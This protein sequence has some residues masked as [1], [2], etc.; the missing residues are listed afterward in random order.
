MD[1]LEVFFPSLRDLTDD[2]VK[3]LIHMIRE[4]RRKP[5][6]PERTKATK[7][8]QAKDKIREIFAKMSDAEKAAIKESLG[9]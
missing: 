7:R 8:L 4:D 6:V 2:E 9:G 1:A 3:Q 5:K